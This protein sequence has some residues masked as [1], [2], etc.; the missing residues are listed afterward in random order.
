MK[1]HAYEGDT[2]PHSYIYGKQWS[3][4]TSRNQIHPANICPQ[5]YFLAVFHHIMEFLDS[6]YSDGLQSLMLDWIS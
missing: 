4:I 6:A 5:N 2:V 3:S 1:E